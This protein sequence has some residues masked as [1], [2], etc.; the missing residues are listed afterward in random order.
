MNSCRPGPPRFATTMDDTRA[1]ASRGSHVCLARTSAGM[2]LPLA[3][4]R[5]SVSLTRPLVRSSH[6]RCGLP[7]MPAGAHVAASRSSRELA[8]PWKEP[9][10]LA[11]PLAGS[12]RGRRGYVRFSRMVE[13]R[14]FLA[15]LWGGTPPS[16][17]P[18][19]SE[20]GLSSCC[21]KN[22]MLLCSIQDLLH[23]PN[24]QW[25]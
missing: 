21:T 18:L 13:A 25:D 7:G 8:W 16:G 15:S 14:S 12:A 6:G 19:Q 22:K 2:E 1:D 9:S 3:G 4:A 10:S 20:N 23:F 24:W 11:W 5:M 17:N